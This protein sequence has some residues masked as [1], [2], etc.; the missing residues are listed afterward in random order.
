MAKLIITGWDLRLEAPSELVK[1]V[2]E[3]LGEYRNNHCIELPKSM[4]DFIHN[5]EAG[6]QSFNAQDGDDWGYTSD[7]VE[8][9]GLEVD[10]A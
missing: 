2:S 7:D 1:V 3:A 8:L 4:S 10:D 5:M 6:Y 9:L